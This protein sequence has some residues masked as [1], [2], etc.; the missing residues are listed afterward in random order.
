TL[1]FP[2]RCRWHRQF[3]DTAT[4]I[5]DC[6]LHECQCQD[7]DM[8]NQMRRSGLWPNMFT[9]SSSLKACA[10]LE[11]P[12]MDNGLH[13]LLTKKDI[14]LDPFVS[15]GLIDMYCKCNLTKDARLIY[16]LML[17]KDL[18]ALNVMI[19]GYSQNEADDVCLDPSYHII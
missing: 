4:I 14:I 9:L 5:V 8:L 6:V 11:L 2:R 18:I 10:A 16:D 13:S 12:E 17:G 19:S 7:I 15:I 1:F 3:P